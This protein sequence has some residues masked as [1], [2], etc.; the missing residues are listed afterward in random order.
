LRD[1][2]NAII[3]NPHPLYYY[4]RGRTYEAMGK[5]QDAEADY[6]LSGDV[7]GPLEMI[8]DKRVPQ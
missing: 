3:L 1:F 7:Q 4:F 5:L 8:Y 6:A 2:T